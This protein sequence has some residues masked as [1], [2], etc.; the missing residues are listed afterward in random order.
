MV[1]K[2]ST[3]DMTIDLATGVWEELNGSRLTSQS[4]IPP[5]V[6]SSRKPLIKNEHQ[7]HVF[8]PEEQLFQLHSIAAVPLIAQDQLLGVLIVGRDPSF[9]YSD[10]RLLSAI[11]DIAANALYNLDLYEDTV[12]QLLQTQALRSID[13]AI[14]A[15]LD[16]RLSLNKVLEQL[17]G[18]LNVDAAAFGNFIPAYRSSLL[19][20]ALVSVQ[21]LSN[22]TSCV[23]EMAI[24]AEL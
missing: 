15:S 6:I 9:N 14:N 20:P 22:E 16:L 10:L 13:Q 1:E 17:V 8:Y 21:K 12:K 5:Q 23:M 4:G 11:G 19:L 2:S 3:Q 24:S 7:S 18:Y